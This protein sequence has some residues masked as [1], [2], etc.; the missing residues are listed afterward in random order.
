MRT[1]TPTD[2]HVTSNMSGADLRRAFLIE[3]LFPPGKVELVQTGLDRAVVGSAVPLAEKLTLGP[4]PELRSGF[5]CERRELGILNIGGSGAVTVDGTR[6]SLAARDAL[7]VGRGSRQIEFESERSSAPARFYL[8][9]YPAHAKFPTRQV[10]REE[11]QPMQLGSRRDANERTIYKYIHADGVQSCQ[12][13]MG[14]TQLKEGSVWN[15]MPP[16]T[17]MRRTEIYLYFDVE[18]DA[19]VMHFMGTPEATRHLVVRNEQAVLS[20]GWSIHCGA[21]TRAYSFAWAMGGENQEFADMDPV[22]VS[23][24]F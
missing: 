14:F 16:H 11:A 12:L 4:T 2:L 20:P 3:A 22:K 15:T 17:H 24:L 18:P 7:Y 13:V 5:L 6:Y 9:S 1:L 23:E 8:V 19:C 10:R 21:G